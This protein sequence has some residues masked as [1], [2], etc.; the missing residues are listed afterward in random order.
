MVLQSKALICALSVLINSQYPCNMHFNEQLVH[1]ENGTLNKVLPKNIQVKIIF[2][3][4]HV[5]FIFKIV[6][7]INLMIQTGHCDK[8]KAHIF[9][10]VSNNLQLYGAISSYLSD[11]QISFFCPF[12]FKDMISD[13]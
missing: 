13:L 6:F 3:H 12:S 5:H 2:Y 9:L 8:Q 1:C 7:P 11:N 10:Y 4:H